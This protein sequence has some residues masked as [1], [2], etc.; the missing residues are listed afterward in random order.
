MRIAEPGE[1]NDRS[2]PGRAAAVEE[3]NLS[4]DV[5]G[6]VLQ[7]P[8]YVGDKVSKGDVL[9]RLD[10]R[11]YQ[12]DL[13][14]SNAARDRAN[15]NYERIAIAARSGAVSRQDLDDALAQLEVRQAEVRIKQKAVEDTV[16]NAPRDGAISATYVE[17]YTAVQAKEPIVRLL[18]TSSIEMV[19]QVPENLISAASDV[20]EAIVEFDAFPGKTIS[21]RIKEVGNEASLTTRTYP[22]KLIMDQPEDFEIVPGMAGKA[23]AVLRE[24]SNSQESGHIV[25]MTAIFTSNAME[26]SGR[27]YVWVV[28]ETSNTV[29]RREVT[30]G[31]LTQY[32][33]SILTGISP[34]ELVVISGVNFL[35]EDQEVRPTQAGDSV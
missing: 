11:D 5:P 10:D 21:A 24:G 33:I 12:N 17:A 3:V 8:V 2:L 13:R 15:A 28:D 32:G 31:P 27:T 16:I 9:A 25:P 23:K 7:R 18:D 22:V 30:T 6:T 26:E 1:I 34:G 35:R 14:A 4:F 19:V 20:A 29:Q